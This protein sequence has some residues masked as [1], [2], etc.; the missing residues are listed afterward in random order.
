MIVS[1][2][3]N[4]IWTAGHCLH[5]GQNGQSGF[6]ANVTFAPAW[7]G[8]APSPAPWG[9]WEASN[10]VVPTTWANGDADKFFDADFGAAI[11]TPLPEY[12]N[13]Q[14]A[15]GAYGYR[16]YSGSDYNDIV[17]FG[18]PADGYNRPDSDFNGGKELMFCQGNVEDAFKFNPLDDRMKMD[19]DMGHG[20]SG[21]PMLTGFPQN[22]KIVGANSHGESDEA[23]VLTSD[24]LY[25]SE[26]GSRAVFVIDTVNGL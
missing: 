12:G 10:L 13:I 9:I 26:H 3:K 17:D 19:C 2:N 5:E 8:D 6:Y 18:Y 16:F 1:N 20:A 23:D 25:S 14:D 15:I 7:D 22:I 4:T 24:N 11:L 21:G